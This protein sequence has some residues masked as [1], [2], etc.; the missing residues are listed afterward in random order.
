MLS[1]AV[2]N[3]VTLLS[4]E[5][6]A[7]KAVVSGQLACTVPVDIISTQPFSRGMWRPVFRVCRLGVG[8][9]LERNHRSHVTSPSGTCC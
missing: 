4:G 9:A 6:A 3:V 8:V 7:V 5:V 2:C 1:V